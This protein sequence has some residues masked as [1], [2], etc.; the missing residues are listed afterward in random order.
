MVAVLLVVLSTAGELARH[1]T[2]A[3]FVMR[4]ARLFSLDGERNV[5]ALFSVFLLAFSASLLARIFILKNREVDRDTRKWVMLSAGFFLMAA[6]EAWSFH[7]T[8]GP[9]I[10]ALLDWRSYGFFYY[11]WI[12]PAIVLVL[13]LG[14]Y[15]LGFLLRLPARLRVNFLSAAGVYLFGVIVLEGVG[16]SYAEHHGRAGLP[17]LV[18]FTLEE[19]CEMMGVIFYIYVL[20]K[21][22]AE[23]DGGIR[24]DSNL[25][26]STGTAGVQEE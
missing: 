25:S 7:E 6:D 5:P 22:L 17:Y 11:A 24:A 4:F 10:R 12:L 19:S 16:G 3:P 15:F 14:L 26:Y 1:A 20:L 13:A 9:P 2:H 21:Y 8:L 23:I 18:L